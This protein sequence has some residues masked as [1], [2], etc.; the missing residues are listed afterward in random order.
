MDLGYAL[1]H[2]AFLYGFEGGYPSQAVPSMELAHPL[3]WTEKISHLVP[4]YLL[5]QHW[6]APNHHL[7][8]NA[9]DDDRLP[10]VAP[11]VGLG[12]PQVLSKDVV[13]NSSF[14]N[15]RHLAHQIYWTEMTE[16]ISQLA[17]S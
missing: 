2:H 1:V 14:C 17:P 8:Q 16:M 3:C 12:P 13:N 5:D 11:S 4:S 10:Q 7:S 6:L 9:C 15:D